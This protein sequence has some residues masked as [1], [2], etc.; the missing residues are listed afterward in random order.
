LEVI[1]VAT[2]WDRSIDRSVEAYRRNYQP[3]QPIS[4][5][6]TVIDEI[7]R[8]DMDAVA[9][10]VRQLA[11]ITAIVDKHWSD[12][13]Q[14]S[15]DKLFAMVQPMPT[16]PVPE[17][18]VYMLQFHPTL[19]GKLRSAVL[20]WGLVLTSIPIFGPIKAFKVV[21]YS[22]DIQRNIDRLA[23]SIY[24]AME[25]QD[26]AYGNTLSEALRQAIDEGA[27][28]PPVKQENFDDWF[29][30]VSATALK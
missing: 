3:V 21:K 1:D 19:G 17:S 8:L 30:S 10:L 5:P 12:L 7:K 2:T 29:A 4:A 14:A 27:C 18:I 15:R 6:L 23:D 13:S 11:D 20:F 22:L 16:H 9:D 25:C 24:T 28:S 26:S